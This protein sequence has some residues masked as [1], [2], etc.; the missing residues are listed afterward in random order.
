MALAA[1]PAAPPGALL[2]PLLDA[3]K[4]EVYAGFYRVPPAAGRRGASRPRRRSRPRRSST[5]LATLPARARAS[6]A[7]SRRT[8]TRSPALP[9]L[10]RRAPSRRPRSPSRALA[11]PR[12][13]GARFDAQ[14]LFALEP[15]YVRPSEAELKFPKGLGPG[16]DP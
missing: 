11:A 4:G 13:L 15:H 3:R 14:A 10:A 16:A 2:V 6:A 8:R 1:A 9:R 7:G 5:R 12:L